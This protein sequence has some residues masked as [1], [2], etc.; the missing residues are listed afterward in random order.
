MVTGSG[1]ARAL[2]M[3]EHQIARLKKK[4]L[5]PGHPHGKR[6]R[7]VVEEARA[8]IAAARGAKSPPLTRT[9]S[10]CRRTLPIDAFLTITVRDKRCK[11]GHSWTGP[12]YDCRECRKE[13]RRERRRK[14]AGRAGRALLAKGEWQAVQRR[15]AVAR[16]DARR[17]AW[18][19]CLAFWA[20]VRMSTEQRLKRS[21]ERQRIRY[22]TDPEYQ[23]K[24]KA[25]K[26]RR[27]RAIRGTQVEPVNREAVAQRDGWRCGIC[28]G[29]VDRKTWSLDHVIPLSRGGSHTYDNVVLAHRSCNSRR[30]TG[31][32]AVQAP[33]FALPAA[34]CAG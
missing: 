4:G 28:G 30:G 26:I 23:A 16:K 6:V 17:V 9:C 5:L 8:A 24:R 1:L 32:L 15:S 3:S 13:Q 11:P 10:L 27:K 21:V 34:I 19:L 25:T 7:Y 14:Q 20:L 31:R 12:S 33:L 2:G 22:N 29:K 18:A